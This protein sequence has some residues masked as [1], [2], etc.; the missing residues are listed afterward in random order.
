MAKYTRYRGEFL[1]RAGVV[2][3]VEI[4]Q[5]SATAY[6]VVGDLDFDADEAVVIDW[7]VTDKEEPLQGSSLTLRVISPGDR[8]YAGL[9]TVKAGEIGVRVYRG[10]V[11]YWAGSLDPEFYEEP[12]ESARGYTVTLTFTDF[13][14]LER[15]KYRLTGRRTVGEILTDAMERA[16]LD[17]LTVDGSMMSLMDEAGTSPVGLGD[18][19]IRSGNFTD[20]EGERSDMKE[21]VEGLLQP[22][23][24]RMRQLAGRLWVYDL[25][26][27]VTKGVPEEVYWSGD[28]QTLGVDKVAN[29]VEVVFS[30][31]ADGTLIDTAIDADDVLQGATE[32]QYFL[33]NHYELPGFR[34]SHGTAS[35]ATDGDAERLPV[36]IDDTRCHIMRIK[37]DYSG[38]DCAGVLYHCRVPDEN[39]HPYTTPLFGV[40]TL[41]GFGNVGT[42][43]P[44]RDGGASP[45]ESQMLFRCRETE[46]DELNTSSTGND[47]DSLKL[48]IELETLFDVRYNPFETAAT[49]NEKG[50]WEKQEYWANYGYVPVKIELLDENNAVACHYENGNVVNSPMDKLHTPDGWKPGEAKWGDAWLSY[51]D[52]NDRKH[53]TGFGGWAKNRQTICEYNKELPTRMTRLGEGEYIDLPPS[54][55]RLRVAVGSGV[56]QYDDDKRA[57]RLDLYFFLRWV[58]YK[59]LKV[60]LVKASGLDVETD[61]VVYRGTLN[62]DADDEIG[63]KT[64]CGTCRRPMP[65]ARGQYLDTSGA[66][67]T[68]LTRGGVT[69]HPERLL[70]GTLCSQYAGRMTVLEGEARIDCGGMKTYTD[71]NQPQGTRFMVKG[72]SQNLIMDTSDVTLVEVREDE[73]QGD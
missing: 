14:I 8:T 16:G 4:V 72:E 42:Y 53:K 23:G 63:I 61:D 25:N 65:T 60:T 38:S 11:L 12:Y 20:E 46:L 58:A 59:D 36:E 56:Y 70:I 49:E 18:I 1:S 55:G 69:D 13:G 17:C 50:H 71:A 15:L 64:I 41:L 66:A 39:G 22:L 57:V 21:V 10:G 19:A 51:Y 2:W 73:Y 47:F 62:P 52:T 32:Y 29:S 35:E 48:K 68:K 43:N 24:W 67:I 30:P 33:D 44:Y 7:D 28:S 37:S 31:Y 6:A 27:L 45:A 34:L 5:E 3:R 40:Y 54:A 26:G 9:Y